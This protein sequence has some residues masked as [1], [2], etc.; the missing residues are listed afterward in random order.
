MEN[1]DSESSDNWER[2][3][4]A[5][6]NLYLFIFLTQADDKYFFFFQSPQ[7]FWLLY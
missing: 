4:E 7:K 5:A 2:R 3:M 6:R 1:W